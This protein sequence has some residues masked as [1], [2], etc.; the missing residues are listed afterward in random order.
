MCV[1]GTEGQAPFGASDRARGD[2][3]GIGERLGPMHI[4][5]RN[6]TALDIPAIADVTRAAFLGSPGT[7]VRQWRDSKTRAAHSPLMR[8]IAQKLSC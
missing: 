3:Q 5:I 6:E 4:E 2:G 1:W 8:R 7:L